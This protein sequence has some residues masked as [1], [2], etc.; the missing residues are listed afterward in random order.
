MQDINE[1]IK[2]QEQGATPASAPASSAKQVSGPVGMEDF[3]AGN[4]PSVIEAPVA[5]AKKAG[6][7]P[8]AFAMDVIKGAQTA[9]DMVRGMQRGVSFGLNDEMAGLRSA[10]DFNKFKAYITGQMSPKEEYEVGRDIERRRQLIAENRSPKAN[11][12]GQLAG[13][14]ATMPF[15]SGAR[16]P[17]MLAHGARA[18]AMLAQGAVRGFGESE[19][20]DVGGL[21]SDAAGGAAWNYAGGKVGQQI[22]K[23]ISALNRS[24]VPAANYTNSPEKARILQKALNTK[25]AAEEQELFKAGL[26]NKEAGE[27]ARAAMEAK[28]RSGLNEGAAMGGTY[29]GG[30]VGGPIGAMIGNQVGRVGSKIVGNIPGVARAVGKAT[31]VGRNIAQ[32][33][34]GSFMVDE[35]K[36]GSSILGR[37]SD[38]LRGDY[39][40]LDKLGRSVAGANPE[41]GQG[42]GTGIEFAGKSVVDVGDV[43]KKLISDHSPQPVNNGAPSS[44]EQA[45]QEIELQTNPAARE[46]ER[47]KR[48]KG[49]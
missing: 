6:N 25:S 20:T 46:A 29:V 7:K 23:G 8:S 30:V 47:M 11:L 31:E 37:G 28:L 2:S 9:S 10:A 16:A 15:T 35:N 17:A 22:G 33:D 45:E 19:K 13:S 3:L 26:A 1:W 40:L 24:I 18:P 36:L 21:A 32:R 43:L 4:T 44:T 42:I 14:V 5:P 41:A 34:P 12:A 39:N 38:A 48:N 49:E 27:A